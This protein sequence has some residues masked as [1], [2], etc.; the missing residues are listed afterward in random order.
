M[1][2]AFRADASVQIGAG[3]VMRCLTLADKLLERGARTRFLCRPSPGHLGDLILARGHALDWLPDA[4]P[5]A[6]ASSQ[7]LAVG[8][9]HDWLV[10]DHYAL[11]ADWERAQRGLVES[12]LAID[13]LADRMHD[14]DVLLDQNLQTGHRYDGLLPAD[15]RV[16]LGPSYALLRP[17]FQRARVA[18]APGLDSV[19]N[20][21]V[22]FGG[23]DPLDL[24]GLTLDALDRLE[25]FDLLVEVVVGQAYPYCDRL[26]A[27]CATRPGTHFHC[28]ADDLAG[29]MARADLAI[30][31]SGVVTWERA[32]VGLPALAITFAD[33]QRPI[34]A[35]AQAAGMLT[36]VGDAGAVSAERLAEAIVALLDAP[37]QRK[38]MRQA[39]LEMVDGAGCGRVVE[40]LS[41]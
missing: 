15:C 14:C 32:C 6:A 12:I 11:G 4:M 25:R 31:A 20:I 39:C 35:A 29:L 33:N 40:A 38:A 34:A 30:G 7:A 24:T 5:D 36:W 16:L 17:E 26:K 22:C 8:A 28:Q 2:V 3:H 41:G 23:S 19:G 21:L 27:R 9:P 37:A 18:I 13:D 1:K 10:V